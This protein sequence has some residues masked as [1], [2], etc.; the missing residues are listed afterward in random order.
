[1]MGVL[2]GRESGEK[3]ICRYWGR[4]CK[5]YGRYDTVVV[6][7]GMSGTAAAISAARGGN[8][9]L[10]I[11]KSI[12]LGGTATNALV[13]PMMPSYATHGT[14][15][16]DI[17]AALRQKRIETRDDKMGYV[18]FTPETMAVVLEELVV[19]AKGEILYD[20][21]FVDCEEADG[22]ICCVYVMTVDGMQAVF[23]DQFIDATGDA[24]LSRAA[25][26]EVTCGDEN[27]NNQMSSLRFEMAG[28][29]VEKYREYC[30]SLQDEFSPLKE[31]YFWESA[32][33]AGRS[34]KLEP[35]FREGVAAGILKEED[36]R[37]YQCFSLPSES[38][39]MTF[40][41]PHISSLTQNMDARA[42]SRAVIEGRQMT[43]RLVRFLVTMMPGFEHAYLSRSAS[44]L[45]IR[46]SCRIVGKYVLT[47]QDYLARARF[48]DAV[49]QGD[50]Y[51]DVHSASKGLVHQD[52]FR[53]G[54]Y[55]EIPY[56]S[57]VNEKVSNL[58]TT[59]RCISTT[60]LMQASIRIIPTV[61]D[62]GESAGKACVLAKQEHICPGM[63]DGRKISE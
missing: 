24:V 25:G 55:Y 41:C 61:I 40:N 60:F 4:E 15:F 11:E 29:D 17:E 9:T 58:I 59:G 62:M 53:P 32:M 6:G 45:G 2:E 12:K 46:E 51:I 30:L 42:R 36:L 27:G 33:V 10:I 7:G 47:E 18:W 28:I 57:L 3:R 8:H 44:M 49:A 16:H 37:Y 43:E 31:G 13:S 1:M 34:F 35:K 20:A 14:V 5:V 22:R 38:G 21:A 50:W 19:A 63:L 48:E 56:R 23:A 39:C 52:K 26:V 54:E